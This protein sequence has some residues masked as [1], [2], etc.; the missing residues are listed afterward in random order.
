MMSPW[1]MML[2][3]WLALALVVTLLWCW[4]RRSGDAGIIDVAWAGGLGALAVFYAVASEGDGAR[5]L[6]LAVMAGFWSIRLASY[7]FFDR[8]IRGDEDGR[9]QS[10]R[11]Q[12]G[13]SVQQKLFLFYHAQAL[14]AVVLSIPYWIVAVQARPFP[15]IFDILGMTLFVVAIAGESVADRQL[16]TF[17]RNPANRGRTCRRGLWKF[18]RHPNYFFEWLHWWTY[19]ILALPSTVA[20]GTTISPLIMWFLITKVTG[21]PPTEEQAL[22]SRGDDYRA[23]QK[24]T[25]AFF[26]WF[27]RTTS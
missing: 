21:I 5:R 20:L 23:Y 16:A 3:G 2:V 19:A 8:V 26:P 15:T 10:L 14:L 13:E 6:I 24:T 7:L 27:P 4:Q 18:S 17:R 9:Y 25:N 22:S 12:W 11:A 1:S